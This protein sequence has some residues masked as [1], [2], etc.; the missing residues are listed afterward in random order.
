MIYLAV[1]HSGFTIKEALERY[2]GSNYYAI[3][4]ALNRIRKRVKIDKEL[5]E[6]VNHVLSVARM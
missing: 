2:G 6:R 4:K 1:N 3:G 5:R